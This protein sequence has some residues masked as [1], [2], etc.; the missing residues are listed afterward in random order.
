MSAKLKNL[1]DLLEHELQDLYSA[2]NQ[3]AEALPKMAKAAT[4]SKLK[5]AFEDHLK[6][7]KT[8]IER[9]EKVGKNLEMKIDGEV[10]KGMKGLI[11][12]GEDMIE[13]KAEKAVHDAGLIAAGQRVEHYEMAGYGTVLNYMKTLKLK[14]SADLMAKTLEEEKQTDEKLSKLAEEINKEAMDSSK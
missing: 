8:Q 1:T 9:L 10:C 11:K 6:Q 2:E 12:E 7:T 3:I 4:N 5:K 13:Q 14:D